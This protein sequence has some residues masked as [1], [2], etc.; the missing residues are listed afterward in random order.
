M[1]LLWP[2]KHRDIRKERMLWE[3]ERRGEVDQLRFM[4]KL[5]FVVSVW[6]I[7]LSQHKQTI[8]NHRI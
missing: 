8:V 4:H 6:Q 5:E 1:L 3:V 7:P 2:V